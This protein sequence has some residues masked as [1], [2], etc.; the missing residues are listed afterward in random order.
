M[1]F[2]KEIWIIL[3][4]GALLSIVECLPFTAGAVA[5]FLS[6]LALS[7]DGHLISPT[8]AFMLLAFINTLR[9]T[10]TR[11]SYAI[12]SVFEL[13]ISL[14]R[15]RNF[16]LLKNVSSMGLESTEKP[17]GHQDR[18]QEPKNNFP[19]LYV[20]G[21]LKA[22]DKSEEIKSENQDFD[23]YFSVD[24]DTIRNYR[25]ESTQTSSGKLLIEGL[26]CKVDELDGPYILHD[27][28]F[29]IPEKSL[30][31]V[32]GEVGSG[33]S[34]LLAAIAREVV[35]SSGNIT[36]SGNVAYVSQTA[37]VFSGT[38]RENVLFGKPFD[39]TKYNRVIQACTLTNDIGRFPNGDLVFVGE[40]GVVL[41][42]GQKARVNL[43][44]AVY[45]NADLYLLDD[46]LSAVDSKVGDHI[47]FECICNL[48][49]NKT[50]VLVTYTERYLR[51]VDQVVVLNNGS[52]S[53]KGTYSE[54]KERGVIIDSI[55]DAS[56][57][58]EKKTTT[59]N[60]ESNLRHNA[61]RG[62][63]DKP[64]PVSHEDTATGD[65]SSSLYWNYFRA[66]MHPFFMILLLLLFLMT[67]GKRNIPG[68]FP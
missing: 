56:S 38:L 53:G 18:V 55:I 12:T 37:W 42:G 22:E 32:T 3:K 51:M 19:E 54:L 47:F 1:S 33:K 20:R 59:P 29:E 46:P 24:N 63:F 10:I 14:K 7:L 34:T 50:R 13:W 6:V 35:A 45:A 9:I 40:H 44:R 11:F 17:P 30:T 57:A 36:Y 16:L 49:K 61:N 67:Q 64:L 58:M 41:S 4:K 52:V 66:G 43:A 23:K 5:T 27:V 21:P 8:T 62:Q 68:N 48:L 2:R 65:I 31:V 26:W 15:I 60:K 28:N 25:T 39:E